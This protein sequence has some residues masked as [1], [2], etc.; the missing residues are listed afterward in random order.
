MRD[1][2]V[3][4]GSYVLGSIPCSWL[5]A[6][7][8]GTSDLRRTGSG[9]V[10]STNVLRTAGVV[11][12]V[13][14]LA[15]DVAKGM[16]AIWLARRAGA[17]EIVVALAG[18]LAVVGHV[19]PV[20]LRFRGG[21]GVATA[22]GVF[23]LLAPGACLVAT[24]VFILTVAVTRYVSLGSM[25]AAVTLALAV[26][27]RPRPAAVAAAAWLTAGLILWRHAEN[28][29]RLKAGR[30]WRLGAPPNMNL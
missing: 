23:A 17:G 18:L 8:F 27:V 16:A 11:P 13:V 29:T 28:I 4:A 19:L 2:L 1:A 9:N 3:L 14:A 25:C 26:V 5:V 7:A 15:L 30:E 22:A 21:K 24:V 20:W 12:G 10:G 6:R